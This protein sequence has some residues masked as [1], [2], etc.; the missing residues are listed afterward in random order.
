MIR[1]GERGYSLLEL[2]VAL[3]LI[4]FISVAIAGGVQFGAR[5]WE[6]SDAKLGAVERVHGA[7]SL[8]RTL[9]EQA[10]PRALDP[11]IVSDPLLFR[12]GPEDLTFTAQAP[13]VFGAKGFTQFVLRVGEARD[14]KQLVLAWRNASGAS[15]QQALLTGAQAITLRYGLRDETGQIDW[16][17]DWREQPG[18]PALVMVSASFA[19]RSRMRW[20]DLVVRTRITQDPQC[21]YEPDTFSCRYG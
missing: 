11:S 17:D 19:P 2:L 7:Q 15:E 3:A 13:S 5:A 21:Q 6:T 4:G 18:A 12:G 9:L 10:I 16:V 8:L 1:Y 14:G 20:P